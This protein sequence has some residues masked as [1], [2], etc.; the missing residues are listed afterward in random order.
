MKRSLLVA[1]FLAAF[2][3]AGNSMGQTAGP[4]TAGATPKAGAVAKT[5]GTA[6]RTG[7]HT[8]AQSPKT[9]GKSAPGSTHGAPN[10]A[11]AGWHKDAT[12]TAATA[13]SWA[14]WLFALRVYAGSTVA[15]AKMLV[16]CPEGKEAWSGS[17]EK[18]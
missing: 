12:H 15:S 1:S 8:A 14:T 17:K 4:K 16:A 13:P 2:A 18:S 11:K 10:Q 7:G 9:A 5:T 3:L 6:G